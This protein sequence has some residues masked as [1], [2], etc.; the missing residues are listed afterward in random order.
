MW[1]KLIPYF[2]K[3]QF[4]SRKKVDES[5]A[6]SCL[7]LCHMYLWTGQEE[8][9][10]NQSL[11][12]ILF[13]SLCAWERVS[14]LYFLYEYFI[15]CPWISITLWSAK[16]SAGHSLSCNNPN[17]FFASILHGMLNLLQWQIHCHLPNGSLRELSSAFQPVMCPDVL[18]SACSFV[19]ASVSIY[20]ME[21]GFVYLYVCRLPC[22]P[23]QQRGVSRRRTSCV[24][25]R[26]LSLNPCAQYSYKNKGT[27]HHQ[28]RVVT[29][30]SSYASIYS[31]PDLRTHFK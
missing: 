17:R 22:L 14:G 30:I 19:T 25:W 6:T 1:H 24:M 3:C 18:P 8:E 13:F 7:W 5:F 20:Y 23:L 27:V 26:D 29:K 2:L 16:R 9:V 12:K 10:A 31:S 28:W 21:C 15:S 4:S 11:K